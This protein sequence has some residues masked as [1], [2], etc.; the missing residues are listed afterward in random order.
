M[1]D[2]RNVERIVK[3]SIR[4]IYKRNNHSNAQL[5]YQLWYL[6]TF[7]LDNQSTNEKK[8]RW[9]VDSHLN[10]S[11]LNYCSFELLFI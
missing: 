5:N 9:L 1:I 3:N 7:K 6:F 11:R 8:S 10:Y 4:S 2:K